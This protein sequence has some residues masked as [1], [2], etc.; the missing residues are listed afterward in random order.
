MEHE[1]FSRIPVFGEKLRIK[2]LNESLWHYTMAT[3][4][5]LCSNIN[6]INFC[7][8]VQLNMMRYGHTTRASF[9]Y[10]KVTGIKSTDTKAKLSEVL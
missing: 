9:I 10:I 3:I 8:S 4:K 6:K 7:V 5:K 2:G 1:H